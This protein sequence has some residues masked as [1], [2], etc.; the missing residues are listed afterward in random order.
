MYQAEGLQC[1]FLF[2]KKCTLL[3]SDYIWMDD[4]NHH[5]PHESL[6]NKTPS[7]MRE[8]V[9]ENSNFEWSSF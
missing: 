2:T 4:Y 7:E 8:L 1:T 6:G 5:R 9:L 3:F